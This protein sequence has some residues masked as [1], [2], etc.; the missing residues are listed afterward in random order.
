M[1]GTLAFDNEQIIALLEKTLFTPKI[2]LPDSPNSGLVTFT[3]PANRIWQIIGASAL[4]NTAA[5]VGDRRPTL[6]L[7]SGQLE[8]RFT[9]DSPQL[10]STT[11]RYAF[12]VG[13]N[14]ATLQEL[15]YIPIPPLIL[16]S[17]SVITISVAAVNPS[18]AFD[19]GVSPAVS[20]MEAV[21]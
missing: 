11:R 21:L 13:L 15:S 4:I 5:T 3:V 17:G 18:D 2:V 10:A 9:A 16:P 12:G 14:L 19:P 1:T 6:I 20:V 8:M 7:K